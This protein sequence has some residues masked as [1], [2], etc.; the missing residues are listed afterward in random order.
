MTFGKEG[1]DEDKLSSPVTGVETVMEENQ[2]RS[3]SP[4]TGSD[5]PLVKKRKSGTFWRRKS[6]LSLASAVGGNSE[7]EAKQNGVTAGTMNGTHNTMNGGQNG[8]GG[9]QGGM[10]GSH[11]DPVVEKASSEKPLPPLTLSP[12]RSRS[13][14]PQLPAFVGGGEGLGDLF[15]DIN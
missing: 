1:E 9:E 3:P 4:E 11:K 10:N 7:V 5:F 6:S 2:A 15:K 14:P 12:I 13:P 8:T